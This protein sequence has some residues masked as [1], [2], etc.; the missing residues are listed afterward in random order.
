M[1]VETVQQSPVPIPGAAFIGRARRVGHYALRIATLAIIVAIAA[2]AI[3][4]FRF[5]D[6]VAGMAAPS[7]TGS[8]EAIVV[9]TGGYQRIDQALD[10]LDQGVGTRLLIS[11]VNPVTSSAELKRVTG[12]SER[13][14]ACCVDMG[15]EALDTIGNANETASWIR[16][17]GYSTVLVVTNNYHMPRS[18]LELGEASPGITFLSYPVTHTDLRKDD[19][20]TDPLAVRTLATEYVKY[21]V[22]RFRNWAGASVASGLRADLAT[23][24]ARPLPVATAAMH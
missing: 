21:T 4:F 2:A 22:A 18:L 19:W 3:G 11:G 17:K 1:S 5:T 15:Y 24:S 14:F 6:K 16:E 23:P 8:V 20:L 10:L 13:L 7:D 12:A 9:L